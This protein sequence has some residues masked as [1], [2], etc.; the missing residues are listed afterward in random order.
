MQRLDTSLPGVY[1][2]RPRIFRDA[3]GFFLETYHRAQFAELGITDSFIQDN[4][5]CSGK[6]TLRGLHYQLRH[7]QAK[8]CRVVE[9]E[10]FDVAVDIRA[11]SPN[12]GKWTSVLLSAEKQN[13]IYIPAGFA[14]GFLALTDRVQFL[15]KCSD[16]YD[17]ADEHGVLWSDPD[18]NISWGATHP[19]VSE[20]DAKY[21]RLVNVPREFLPVYSGT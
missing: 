16:F 1:E 10:A 4:H 11:G 20:K 9:G 21:P 17:S 7:A 14:H 13:Q 19:L 3:R 8:V 18:L 12:F 15:Y 2:L 6:G 5:S